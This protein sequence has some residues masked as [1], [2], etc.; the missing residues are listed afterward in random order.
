M[1]GTWGIPEIRGSKSDVTTNY[2]GLNGA[3]ATA[4]LVGNASEISD[5][6]REFIIPSTGWK[7][8]VSNNWVCLKI[9]YPYTQWLMII[10]PIKWLFHW[11]YTLFSD[12]PNYLRP[13]TLGGLECHPKK[14]RKSH[15]T[16]QFHSCQPYQM[17]PMTF[18]WYP[19]A[20]IPITSASNP[21]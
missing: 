19:I 10:I 3:P 15:R 9:V 2:F 5:L 17:V 16:Q 8:C 4:D 12:K 18:A 6:S 7:S 11:E 21:N 20:A 1:L 13:N 14:L